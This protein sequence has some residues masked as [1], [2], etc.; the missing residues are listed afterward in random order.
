LHKCNKAMS[1]MGHW[2]NG[3]RDFQG[4]SLRKMTFCWRIQF[5]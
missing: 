5:N 3:A 4:H 1:A 2:G